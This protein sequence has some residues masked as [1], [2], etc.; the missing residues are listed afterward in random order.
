[1]MRPKPEPIAVLITPDGVRVRQWAH[2]AELFPSG[3][4]GKRGVTR[5]RCID[6]DFGGRYPTREHARAVADEHMIR[7]HSSG[8]DF[9]D[10]Q[11]ANGRPAPRWR[12]PG[13]AAI[14]RK[15]LRT[16]DAST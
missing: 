16:G 7:S 13:C 11:P 5:V 15:A 10:S 12:C 14:K 9:C 1:M 3:S 6:C 2:R 8:S 4:A